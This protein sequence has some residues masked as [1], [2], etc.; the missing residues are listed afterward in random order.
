M[1][2]ALC[3]C[4]YVWVC[5]ACVRVCVL[6]MCV[7]AHI[8]A[9]V[10]VQNCIYGRVCLCVHLSVACIVWLW[11]SEYICVCACV[12]VRAHPTCV[13]KCAWMPVNVCL[14]VR[15]ANCCIYWIPS[16]RFIS[17]YRWSYMS[18]SFFIGNVF[19]TSLIS[20]T[21]ATPHPVTPRQHRIT[22][23]ARLTIINTNFLL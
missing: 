20:S 1:F 15:F 5:C 17:I 23:S 3:I 19:C 18:Q 21:V 22:S 10:H 13:H 12:Y 4:T 11:V 6:V 7:C 16:F 2:T 14:H 9:V 8:H